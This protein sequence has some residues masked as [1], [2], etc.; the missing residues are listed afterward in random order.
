M[1]KG[2][3]EKYRIIWQHIVGDL[4][5]WQASEKISLRK[6]PLT[7]SWCMCRSL[8]LAGRRMVG[9][10]R[11]SVRG[12]GMSESK[13]QERTCH[14]LKTWTE[15]SVAGVWRRLGR[16]FGERA[17]VGRGP[18]TQDLVKPGVT[19]FRFWKILSVWIKDDFLPLLETEIW[20]RRRGDICIR[21]VDSLC[22]ITETNTAL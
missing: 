20:K 18:F 7:G 9:C 22:C 17:K 5:I 6:R 19:L 13:R 11:D 12:N 3:K 21:I 15:A 10:G 2:I 16:I 4:T 1:I 14:L 8:P